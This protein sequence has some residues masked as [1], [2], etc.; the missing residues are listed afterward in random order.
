MGQPACCSELA[1]PRLI[2][3]TCSFHAKQIHKQTWSAVESNV[4]IICSS[5]PC[6]RPLLA[7]WLPRVFTTG[8]R[9]TGN[10]NLPSN[11]TFDRSAY[12]RHIDRDIVLEAM[13][14]SS[15]RRS[16]DLESGND[17]IKVVT[18]VSIDVADMKESKS[19]G[20][21]AVKSVVFEKDDSF[22]TLVR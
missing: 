8:H 17:G 16:G 11:L 13:N 10:S 20:R 22:E 12:G 6:L 19:G 2:I 1:P 9:S 15:S 14:K 21:G 4:G 3:Y 18:Q 5:L 7:R